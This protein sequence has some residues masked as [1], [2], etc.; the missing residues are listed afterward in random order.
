M[1]TH[2]F[3][4]AALG[5]LAFAVPAL[6]DDTTTTTSGSTPTAQQQ[7]RTERAQMGTATFAATYGTNANKSNAFGKCVSKRASATE[8]A[9]TEAKTN[10]AQQC[11]A[12]R[13]AD[14]AAFET[15]YGTGKNK[16][17][18]YG[19]CVSGKAKAQTTETVTAEV[20][21][22]VSA[23]KSCKAERK[24]DPAAFKA[25]YGTNRNKSNAFGKCVSAKAKAQQDE[26]PQQS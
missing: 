2:Q 21:A 10:A 22:D 19:K 11:K 9:Q 25:K 23:A 20:Q 1:K 12:E 5:A 3:T 16:S 14:P 24:A 8:T 17:N 6:A 26:A 4:I 7:C 13:T 18:A 15:K